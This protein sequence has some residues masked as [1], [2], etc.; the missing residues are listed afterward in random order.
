[1]ALKLSE[2]QRA[3]L[4]EIKAQ[5]DKSKEKIDD[6]IGTV[7]EEVPE[8]D[9]QGKTLAELNEQNESLE[10]TNATLMSF[11][12]QP[13][14]SQATA[15]ELQ[16]DDGLTHKFRSMG[17]FLV[18]L[19]TE[20]PNREDETPVMKT[21]RATVK[22]TQTVGDA[23]AG[24]TLVPT[25]Y[26]TEVMERQ[27]ETNPILSRATIIPMA[28]GKVS[29]PFIDGFDESKGKVMGNGQF[30]WE[31]EG[32]AYTETNAEFGTTE[33]N[34]RKCTGAVRVSWELLKYSAV[35]I[36]GIIQKMFTQGVGVAITRGMIRGTGAKQPKGILKDGGHKIEVAKATN[37]VADTYIYDNILDQVAQQYS[38]GGD[39]GT[40]SFL[41]NK[42]VLP[43]L[44]KLS[45]SVGTGGSGIFLVNQ[46]IQGRP[47]F[48][49]LGLA[50]DFN[51]QMPIVGDAG[52]I[53]LCDWPNGYLVGQPAGGAGVE[54]AESMHLYF[55]YGDMAF[56]AIFPMDGAPWWPE[57]F[58]PA[59]GD[60][61]A[62]FVTIAA[63]A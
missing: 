28:T 48:A 20:G 3:K 55:N 19:A 1:M 54:T 39:I 30:Y 59:Y 44:G 27:R 51:G 23:Q 25:E 10:A 34:L 16:P 22:A 8:G 56:R 4:E 53:T 61:Q 42:T 9:Y 45:I 5:N 15:E 49:L 13:D 62:P 43:Q 50:V 12:G 38:P 35:S 60:S 58:K 24:G 26:V 40:G 21:W 63:R 14:T 41:A 57:E 11:L 46:S 2:E 33:L 32:E 18:Q 47:T 6:A 29:I 52:D 17:D 37:Q 31:G 36:E 7:E